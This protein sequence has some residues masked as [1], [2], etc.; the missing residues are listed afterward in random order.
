VRRLESFLYS[1]RNI[2]GTALALGG[3]ALFALGVVGAPIWIPITAGLYAIGYLLVPGEPELDLQLGAAQDAGQVR[4]GLDRLLRSIRGKVADDL[5]AKAV[6]IRDSILGTLAAEG[7][8]NE[9]DPN[10]YLIR[11][12]A[13]SYLPEA[14]ATYLRMPRVMAER[15]RVADGRTP[16]DVFLEQLDLMDRKLEDVADDIARHD[17]DKLLANGR[18]IA[19][20]FGSSALQIDP[21][22]A[23]ATA[24]PAPAPEAVPAAEPV[25]LEQPAAREQQPADAERVADRERV[26]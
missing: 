3:P 25:A 23:G 10:V 8:G 4:D 19:D 16:H 6:R 24:A 12:T 2:V 17:S 26:H 18:F 1:R 7:A 11:Q 22:A 21:T 20:K 14:F 13:L 9:A 15:R 5:Y